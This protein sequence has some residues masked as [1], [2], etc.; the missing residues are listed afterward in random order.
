MPPFFQ[1]MMENVRMLF[2]SFLVVTSATLCSSV[3]LLKRKNWA[4]LVFIIILSL[5]IV[6]NIAGFFF[7]FFTMN[8]F[9]GPQI[10]DT[11]FQRNFNTMRNVILIFTAI[12]S[13]GMSVLFGW[14]IRKLSSPQIREEFR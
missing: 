11:E 10:P 5:G 13:I 9:P 3:G 14:L 4:R 6:W 8:E 2:A 1:F 12:L 7:Q